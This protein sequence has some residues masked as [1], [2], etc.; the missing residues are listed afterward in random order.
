[1]GNFYRD[2]QVSLCDG[3]GSKAG[4]VNS[5][6]LEEA[7]VYDIENVQLVSSGTEY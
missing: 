2:F 5:K 1:M 4:E 6:K 3:S 7:W